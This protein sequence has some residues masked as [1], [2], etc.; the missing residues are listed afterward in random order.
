MAKYN[1]YS[2]EIKQKTWIYRMKSKFIIDYWPEVANRSNKC[3]PKQGRAGN[4]SPIDF[5]FFIF[6]PIL[7]KISV[8]PSLKTGITLFIITWTRIQTIRSDYPN[9]QP[10]YLHTRNKR[11]RLKK[12]E[13]QQY[14]RVLPIPIKSNIKK[15]MKTKRAFTLID[16]QRKHRPFKSLNTKERKYERLLT[17]VWRWRGLEVEWVTAWAAISP[18][19]HIKPELITWVLTGCVA[20]QFWYHFHSLNMLLSWDLL[21]QNAVIFYFSETIVVYYRYC[22]S[23][24]QRENGGVGPQG[25][26]FV[27]VGL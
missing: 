23:N 27:L 25:F 3:K 26:L 14:E 21:L 6:I 20:K 1:T 19:P 18:N 12:I 22:S 4:S 10:I 13:K 2:S 24:F 11:A 8:I 17:L 7:Q 15:A 5:Q 9:S 16:K